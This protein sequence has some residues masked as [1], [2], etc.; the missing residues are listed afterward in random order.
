MTAAHCTCS[1]KLDDPDKDPQPHEKS[2][3][4]PE[5]TNQIT[6][7]YNEMKIYGGHMNIDEL[8]S[9]ENRENHFIISY[10]YAKDID[11]KNL[12]DPFVKSDIAI[13][14]SNKG[15]FD[16]DSLKVT[17]PLD[18]PSMVPICL[19]AVDTNLIKKE[20]NGVGWGLIYDESPKRPQNPYYSS[21]MTNEVGPEDWR[22]EHCNWE[23]LKENQMSCR[24]DKYPDDVENNDLICKRA[25]Y[26]LKKQKVVTEIGNMDWIDKIHIHTNDPDKPRWICYNEKH[27]VEKGWCEVL[28]HDPI[29]RNGKGWGFCS[30]SCK[31]DLLKVQLDESWRFAK[32]AMVKIIIKY[33]EQFDF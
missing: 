32:K 15:L 4:K 5:Y 27:L 3:C 28:G 13:L 6:P 17:K 33:K 20:I 14:I 11:L 12:K 26:E 30:P 18:R 8:Q 21:C 10:A 9:D 1:S 29:K 25:F 19:A 31:D 2:I 7:K 24:K 22:F 16:H 23:Q